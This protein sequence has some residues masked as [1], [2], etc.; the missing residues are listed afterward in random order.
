MQGSWVQYHVYRDEGNNEGK[1]KLKAITDSPQFEDRDFVPGR[2]YGLLL[3]VAGEVSSERVLLCVVVLA[4]CWA[5]LCTT[6]PGCLGFGENQKTKTCTS[7]KVF[8][9]TH[10]I[11]VIILFV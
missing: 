1:F 5:A 6:N 4:M 7:N 8:S 2:F 10:I 9:P 11:F 3:G